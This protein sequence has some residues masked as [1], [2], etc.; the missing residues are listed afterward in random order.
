MTDRERIICA[1]RRRPLHMQRNDAYY[2]DHNASVSC[3][4][5]TGSSKRANP[6]RVAESERN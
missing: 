2:H 4:P 1:S 5:G 3:Y 6:I